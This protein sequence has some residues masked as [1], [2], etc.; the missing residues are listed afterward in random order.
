MILNEKIFV[1]S[2]S[3]N[4]NF[5]FCRIPNQLFYNASDFEQ[6]NVSSQFPLVKKVV[7]NVDCAQTP[8]SRSEGNVNKDFWIANLF[9]RIVKY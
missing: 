8:M 1:R 6:L 3:L 5:S 9:T 4:Q 7:F 2:T